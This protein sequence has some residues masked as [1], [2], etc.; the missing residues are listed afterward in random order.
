MS[1]RTPLFA[2]VLIIVSTFTGVPCGSLTLGHAADD[3]LVAE[4]DEFLASEP[5]AA[6]TRSATRRKDAGSRASFLLRAPL[7]GLTALGRRGHCGRCGLDLL[8]MLMS[9]RR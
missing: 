5:V 7:L 4:G 2:L 1:Q 3:V 6:R 8:Y 9:L